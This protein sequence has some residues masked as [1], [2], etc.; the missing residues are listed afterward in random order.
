MS[1]PEDSGRPPEELEDD[2]EVTPENP[3][4]SGTPPEGDDELPDDPKVLKQRLKDTQRSFHESQAKL[5]ETTRKLDKLSG[6]MEALEQSRTP[7]TAEEVKDWLDE[8]FPDDDVAAAPQKTKDMIKRLRKE[9]GQVL[10]QRDDYLLSEAEK[11]AVRKAR[12]T[13][14]DE[15]ALQQLRDDP[16]YEGFSDEQLVTILR[17]QAKP[18]YERRLPP[19]IGGQRPRTQPRDQDDVTKSPLFRMM[20]PDLEE[21]QK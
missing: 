2:T 12:L 6:R 11:R 20:Y 17:K 18:A 1:K 4:D 5:S 7:E 16:D 13:E 10:R 9:I 14:V 21:D 3:D 8:E 19:K 15:E